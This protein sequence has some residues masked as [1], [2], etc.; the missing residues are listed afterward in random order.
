MKFGTIWAI[1]ED[2]ENQKIIESQTGNTNRNLERRLGRMEKITKAL[3]VLHKI[4]NGYSLSNDVVEKLMQ[5][6]KTLFQLQLNTTRTMQVR[7]IL[8][9]LSLLTMN[10]LQKQLINL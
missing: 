3:G 5:E 9:F 6:T 1:P 4:N 7:D 2:A 8:Q 10:L